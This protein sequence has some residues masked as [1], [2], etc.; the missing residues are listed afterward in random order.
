MT[1]THAIEVPKNM[2][3]VATAILIDEDGNE[4]HVPV[5]RVKHQRKSNGRTGDA[6]HHILAEKLLDVI[7]ELG[8]PV[9]HATSIIEAFH[10]AH[11]D[12]GRAGKPLSLQV[13]SKCLNRMAEEGEHR[14]ALQAFLTEEDHEGVE[15]YLKAHGLSREDAEELMEASHLLYRVPGL[16][17]KSV[18]MKGM[19]STRP[20]RGLAKKAGAA[21]KT[22]VAESVED[23]DEDG[24][25][26]VAKPVAK[27]VKRK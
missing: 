8:T 23:A 19:Y 24:G 12:A 15:E 3:H 11:P 14:K 16:N 10:E 2:A 9:N 26:P 17:S 18:H 4:I 1:H 27:K 22:V 6:A 21:V 20:V 7:A 5:H 13:L 25:E